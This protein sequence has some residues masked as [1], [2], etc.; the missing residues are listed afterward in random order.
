MTS[1]L[2]AEI[3]HCLKSKGVD[4]IFGIPGVHNQELYRGIEEAGIRHVLARHEQGAGF[5]A[6]G[7]A[8][9]T[10]L[11]GVVYVISGP[12][13]C[14][15]M[16]PMGQAYSD[17][18]PML[19]I[20]SGLDEVTLEPGR[21][22][23]HEM[24]DQRAAAETVC[25]WAITAADETEAYELIDRAFL[26]FSTKRKR[27][28][29]I[30]VPIPL[31]EKKIEKNKPKEFYSELEIQITESRTPVSE[32]N[33]LLESIFSEAPKVLF[34]FG[35]GASRCQESAR[36]AL[37]RT[38]AACFS[39]YS[40]RGIIPSD[41]PLNFGSYLARPSSMDVIGEAEIVIAVGTSLS[42]V[43][44]WRDSLG[45]TGRF[46]WVNIDPEAFSDQIGVH[47]K[48]VCDSESFL[49]LLLKVVKTDL[50]INWDKTLVSKFQKKWE[51]EADLE[52]PGIV[53]ICHALRQAAPDN[54]TFFSD[55]TQFAYVGKEVI[56]MS[57]SNHWHH[58]YGFGTLGYALPAAIGGAVGASGAPVI[59]IAGDYGFQYTIQEL[60]TAVEL[61]LGLPIILWDNGKLKEIEDSMRKAQIAPNAVIAKN[62][63]F[64][65]LAEAYG[66]LAVAP[67][68]IKSFKV[69]I[70][71]A[72]KQKK[73][74]LIYITEKILSK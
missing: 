55:M 68:D 65:K 8:R 51:N 74:T 28:K 11:P 9:I 35:G 63:D 31:L 17:S 50:D 46:I 15:V 49:N 38:S 24:K 12:G 72:F 48:V 39:T 5:M 41:D 26:E 29:Y 52:R 19:I 32:I 64:C 30:Q 2:G 73:P 23:L 47:E 20:A 58:P 14:N 69:S 33:Q 25:D 42:E 18:V 34:I 60:A 61:E 40:G 59:A 70:Q 10:G 21:G 16:T 22:Q 37:C 6:D 62:P 13:V 66:A 1:T 27:P 53:E 43:D 7:F 36:R 67:T 4:I 57:L 44:L 45:A 71:D 54:T 3:S 56:P